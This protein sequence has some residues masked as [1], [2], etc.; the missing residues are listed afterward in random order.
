MTRIL[1]VVALAVWPAM[2]CASPETTDAEAEGRTVVV[3]MRDNHF[4]PNELQ[5][6]SDETINF[7]FVNTGKVRHDAFI[8]DEEA[9]AEHER[10]ARQ[11]GEHGGHTAD[12]TD[13]VLVDPGKTGSLTYTF[14]EKGETLIGCHEPGHYE[15]G[16]VAT[17]DVEQR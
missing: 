6:E 11:S 10:A 3:Y 13:A 5:V 12:A 14:E 2:S 8:G 9:Q 16:M 17:V 7:R 15:A 4:E 1:A